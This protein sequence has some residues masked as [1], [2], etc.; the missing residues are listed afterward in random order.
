MDNDRLLLTG[1]VE[2][3]Y[4]EHRPAVVRVVV[5]DP[6]YNSTDGFSDGSCW[7]AEWE[8]HWKTAAFS[9]LEGG[10]FGFASKNVS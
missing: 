3:K 6:I 10:L 9:Q 7:W 1:T 4:P 2:R 8:L 5:S